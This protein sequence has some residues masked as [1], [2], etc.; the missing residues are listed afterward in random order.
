MKLRLLILPAALVGAALALATAGSAA[1]DAGQ[2]RD[3]VGRRAGASLDRRPSAALGV[4]AGESLL[5]DRLASDRR[6]DRRDRRRVSRRPRG[7]PGALLL[8]G[9]RARDL[10]AF[11]PGRHAPEPRRPGGQRRRGRPVHR[12]RPRRRVGSGLPDRSGSRDSARPST[13]PPSPSTMRA[14][15]LL[16][17]A[18]DPGQSGRF[19]LKPAGNCRPYPEAS[20]G[21]AGK[22]FKGTNPDGTVF[23]FAD[24]HLHIT[25]EMRAGGALPYGK[26]F[27]PL[28][29]TEALG[30][31]TPASRRRWKRRRDRQPAARRTAVRHPRHAR[32]AQLRGLA[33][34]PT[35]TP[36]SRSITGG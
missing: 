19:E 2:G 9:D 29:V 5:R 30:A 10:H 36:T 24:T 18:T 13:A 3:G 16:A 11:R 17:V 7:R 28:R 8:Q 31:T 12:P 15:A 1:P 25:S 20:P 6:P 35:P 26:S 32:L 23:G 27:P 34:A 21:A 14:G 33:G 22:P 4:R